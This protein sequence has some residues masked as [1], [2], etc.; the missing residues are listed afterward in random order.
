M[1]IF[2]L[3]KLPLTNECILIQKRIRFIFTFYIIIAHQYCFGRNVAPEI[4]NISVVVGIQ[5]QLVKIEYDL[6]DNEND[7]MSVAIRISDDNGK[8]FNFFPDS[9]T[10]HVGYPVTSGNNKQI[11]LHYNANVTN[12]DSL[13]HKYVVKIIADDRQEMDIHDIIAQ[14]DSIQIKNYLHSIYGIRCYQ[15]DPS[16]V[17]PKKQFIKQCFENNGLDAELQSFQYYQH[18]ADNIIGTKHG[19]TNEK[20]T[21]ILCGH[22]DTSDKSP[23]AHDNGSGVAGMLEVMRV[24]SAFNFEYTIKFI[25]F[26]LEESGLIGSKHYVENALANKE[27]II[28]VINL[29]CIGYYCNQPGCH[30]RGPTSN[31]MRFMGQQLYDLVAAHNFVGDFVFNIANN[32][33][34]FMM[35][36]F[37]SCAT[38]YVPELNVLSNMFFDINGGPSSD[39]KYFWINNYKAIFISDLRGATWHTPNDTLGIFNFNYYS[40]IVKTITAVMAKFAQI[41]HCGVGISKSVQINSHIVYF[42]KTKPC[43]FHLQ[44]NYPNPFNPSTTI[45]FQLSNPANVSLKIYNLLG[46][47]V[48]TILNEF[49]SAGTY[50]IV[51]NADGLS[52]GLYF[53]K[54]QSGNY[55]KMRK[56]ILQK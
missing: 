37:D 39:H 50:R 35:D 11:M 30:K 51:W 31:L 4:S 53:M 52:G 29:D 12:E 2:F 32:N 22:Y 47:H 20:K 40:Q 7:L 24:L 28:G 56:L 49:R 6:H 8:T 27:D 5:Q 36:T 23:G 9:L 55:T 45:E 3:L 43:H 33:S 1:K 54:M 16:Q 19:T 18:D 10:G 26:D 44:Q 21:V 38:T 15:D 17:E 48:E 41:Q 13:M 34:K 42:D 14:V 46:E 25:A